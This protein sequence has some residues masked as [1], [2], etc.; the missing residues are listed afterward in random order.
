MTKHNFYVYVLFRPWD[1][2]PFYIGKGKDRRWAKHA[3]RKTGHIAS[4]FKKAARLGLEV[5]IVKIRDDLSEA[6]AFEIE[7]ALIRAI[8][9]KD[10][11]LGPLANQTDGGEGASN[12]PAQVIEKRISKI[13]G[14]PRPTEVRE[15]IS[16]KLR[17]H[18]VSSET[19]SKIGA[20]SREM[21]DRDRG[22]L[23]R[24]NKDRNYSPTAETRMAVSK[25]HLGR[26]RS[27]ETCN[28]LRIAA[29][30]REQNKRMAMADSGCQPQ[31]DRSLP[32]QQTAG[33]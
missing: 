7:V 10:L 21:W 20:K 31:L 12:P 24:V 33:E 32:Y 19:K 15:A 6:E 29:L 26:K 23:I 5:P 9:R 27:A 22:R 30:R 3:Q 28:K 13:R 4:V 11:G 1:G 18:A 16:A 17:G 25:V 2:S 8:G 14:I